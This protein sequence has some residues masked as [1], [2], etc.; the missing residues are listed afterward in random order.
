MRVGAPTSSSRPAS[1]AHGDP[2]FPIFPSAEV[3]PLHGGSPSY[4]P[5]IVEPKVARRVT[6]RLQDLPA[7]LEA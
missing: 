6:A 7:G 1:K 5:E 3:V 4:Q 2:S